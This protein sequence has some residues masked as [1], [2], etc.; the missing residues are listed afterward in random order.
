MEAEIATLQAIDETVIQKQIDEI[1]QTNA[2]VEQNKLYTAAQDNVALLE[3][4][5]KALTSKIKECDDQK[6]AQIEFAQ[7]PMPEL[8]F[9]EERGVLLNNVPFAQGS[10]ARQLQASIAIGIALNP[11]VRV[12]LIRDGSLLDDKSLAAVKET[13]AASKTQL[14]VE[15]VS[16]KDPSAIVIEDGEVKA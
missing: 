14:W 6:A 8:G 12:I 11:K 10:Q 3:G 2:G 15:C 16:S 13:C 5:V 7:F 1:Q 9:D 4:T